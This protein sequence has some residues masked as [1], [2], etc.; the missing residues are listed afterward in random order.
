MIKCEFEDGNLASLR[1]AVIDTIVFKDNKILMVKRT[2]KL[3]EGGKWGLIGGYCERNE[4]VKQSAER[5]VHEE[6]GWTIKDLRLLRVVD[7]PDRPNEDRQNI[8]FVFVAEAIEK[9]GE[10]DWESDE[11]RWFALDEIPP[12]KMIAFDHMEDIEIY[13]KYIAGKLDLSQVL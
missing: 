8:S 13:K 9:T 4:T 6:T 12:A 3:L 7:N 1:H 5:E 2:A 11:Q 10:P